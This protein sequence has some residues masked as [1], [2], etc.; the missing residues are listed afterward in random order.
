MFWDNFV[1]LVTSPYRF[2]KVLCFSIGLIF[3]VAVASVSL[4]T[5]AFIRSTP[6]FETVTFPQLKALAQKR[7]AQ[8]SDNK[9]ASQP[10]IEISQINRDYIY[11]VV[12]SEDSSFFEH[13]G[14][15]YD[16]IARSIAENIKKKKYQYGASTITQQVVKNL[17]L[18]DEKTVSRKIREILITD[19]LES[20]FTKNQILEIYL[21]IAEFGPD[22]FGVAAAAGHYFGKTPKE[23]NVAEGAFIAMMLPSPRKYHYS[24]FENRNLTDKNRRKIVRI[25]GDMLANELISYEQYKKFVKYDYFT[26][27]KGKR[28][29]ARAR[30]R[31]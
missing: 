19:R 12:M 28:E 14:V 4:F 21:N 5:Y 29:P 30:K 23:I 20:R 2:F 27:S 26:K 6:R 7:I 17:F 22:I 31:P 9:T 1:H 11:T 18:T 13:D 16:A 24:V 8:K 3:M 15:N 10:W 25:I